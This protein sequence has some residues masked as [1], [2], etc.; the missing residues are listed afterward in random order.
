[1]KTITS[2]ISRL[3]VLLSVLSFSS[4]A[5]A[6]VSDAQV[7]QLLDKSGATKTI[8]G[9]PMQ[10]QAM[11]QQIA[12]TAKNPAEH[13]KFM[14]TFLSSLN[15]DVMLQ[16]MV[17]YVKK[18]ASEADIAP[19]LTWLDSDLAKRMISAELQASDPQFQQNLMG[20]MGQ[21]QANPPSPER[22]Q[23]I[24]NYVQSSAIVDQSMKVVM[25]MVTNMFDALK[26]SK[27]ENAEIAAQLDAQVDQM[28]SMMKPAL[29]Q[30]MTLTS[31]YIYRD[32]SNEDINQYA[33]FFTQDVGKKYLD[34]LMGAVGE[35]LNEWGVSLVKAIEKE[36]TQS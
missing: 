14:E 7:Y 8:E 1:M 33:E 2:Y 25:A 19:I 12:L 24:I 16:N 27:P 21:L 28:A 18:N 4:I 11:G 17:G 6:Q 22:T 23:T 31:Y 9:L 29:E 34:I 26:A 10:M 15:T 13:Q 32:M 20:F 5:A 35:G 36:Q 3:F 30:Q